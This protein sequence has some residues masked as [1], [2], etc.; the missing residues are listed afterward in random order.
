MPV[1]LYGDIKLSSQLILRDVLFVP[2][3]HF[4]LIS[5]SALITDNQLT[6]HFFHDY[7]VIQDFNTKTNDWQGLEEAD[8][9][10]LGV[11]TMNEKNIR[12]VSLIDS[13]LA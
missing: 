13:F 2:Q 11:G 12:H 4:I 1:I 9:Y 7:F 10:I 5:V 8:L 3:F 6:V